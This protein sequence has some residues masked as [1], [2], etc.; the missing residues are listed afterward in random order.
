MTR[1]MTVAEIAE[2]W[3]CSRDSVYELIG[4]GK[5]PAWG[6]G[7]NAAHPCRGPVGRIVYSKHRAGLAYSA[8]N[9]VHYFDSSPDPVG[10][11]S[12]AHDR[13]PTLS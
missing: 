3:S 2:R 5:L 8:F 11:F 6:T 13:A 12:S 1:I 10:R 9:T 7:G 4:R